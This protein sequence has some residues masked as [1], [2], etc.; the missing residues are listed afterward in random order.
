MTT[1]SL[2]AGLRRVVHVTAC[3]VLAL[4]SLALDARADVLVVD[5][6]DPSSYPTLQAAIDAA[7]D[8]DVIRVVTGEIRN[9]GGTTSDAALAVIDGKGLTVVGADPSP[10]LTFSGVSAKPTLVVRN[11]AADQTVVVRNLDLGG[12]G[13]NDDFWHTPT[14]VRVSN[15]DGSVLFE[16]CTFVG[17]DGMCLL[18][19]PEWS[20]F[21]S[22]APGNCL[23]IS[24]SYGV[25]AIRCKMFSGEV[26]SSSC[27][28][29]EGAQ[30]VG[31][32]GSVF[33]D[34]DNFGFGP[35][36]VGAPFA[37]T[38]LG[39]FSGHTTELTAWLPGGS[40][41]SLEVRG[42]AGDGVLLLTSLDV[43]V[44]T[45]PKY[46]GAYLLGATFVS[47]NLPALPGSGEAVYPVSIPPLPVGTPP[48]TVHAQ[49]AF[50][51]PDG[52]VFL[53][54]VTSAAVVP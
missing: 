10:F 16:D 46:P 53:G 27:G 18:I 31:T 40:T 29:S 48:L 17:D 52:D 14:T 9:D 23:T 34:Y 54:S 30:V 49:A 3:A 13:L 1:L 35:F 33:V 7:V 19:D 47:L 32:N 22:T 20:I 36:Y 12:W 8:G 44:A 6:G 38:R 28:Y 43:G 51:K 45:L 41:G 39:P 37:S 2:A 24:S 21:A 25:A 15:C 11:V 42:G 5:S 26:Q 4:A 50:L